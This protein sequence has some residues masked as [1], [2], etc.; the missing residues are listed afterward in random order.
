M[1]DASLASRSSSSERLCWLSELWCRAIRVRTMRVL[2][3]VG[4][5]RVS[6]APWHRALRHTVVQSAQRKLGVTSQSERRSRHNTK[7]TTFVKSQYNTLPRHSTDVVTSQHRRG[8]VTVQRRSRHSTKSVT[9]QY[10][11]GLV[12]PGS[13]ARRRCAPSAPRAPAAACAVHGR[14]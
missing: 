2:A 10:N 11:R 6:T 9:S 1:W 13:S 7:D 5:D 4:P 12:A 8:H 14:G 3:R